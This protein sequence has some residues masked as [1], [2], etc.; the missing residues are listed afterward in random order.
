MIDLSCRGNYIIQ[1]EPH[2]NPIHYD[3]RDLKKEFHAGLQVIVKLAN[4]ELKP[5]ESY[6]GGSWHVEGQS[7]EHIVATALYYYD[8]KNITES[9]LAFRQ[10][11][12]ESEF[13]YKTEWHKDFFYEQGEDTFL[14]AVFGLVNF[15]STVQEIGSVVCREG[16]LLTFPNTLQHCVSPFELED[17]TKPGH[18]KILALFL[19]D[20]H[21]KI[22]STKNVPPQQKDWWIGKLFQTKGIAFMEKLPPEIVNHILSFIDEPMSLETAKEK[23]L[24][25]IAERSRYVSEQDENFKQGEY[26]LC[27]H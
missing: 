19:V 7:N 4:I 18:R 1:P 9:R 23:R 14:P 16:R 21:L 26:S 11:P 6:A 5:G 12:D 24:E 22:I 17:K 10:A 8:S 3:V 25:L 15:E 13:E 2:G 27:E 20:P